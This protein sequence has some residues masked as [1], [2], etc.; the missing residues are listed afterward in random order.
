MNGKN[1]NFNDKKI[2]K[3]NFYKNKKINNIED[4][5]VDNILVSKKEPYGTLLDI[6]IMILLDHPLC[7]KLPQMTGYISKFNENLTMSFRVKDKQLLKNYNKIWEKVEKLMKIDFESK[8]VYGND[9]KYIKTKIKTYE[10]SIITNF[11]DKKTPKEKA[12]Y[13]CLSIIMIDSVIKAN[14]KYYPQPLLEE[15]KYIQKKMKTENY[16]DEELE[17]SESDSESNSE[18]ESDTDNEE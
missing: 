18:T 10:K 15:C 11:H 4:I 8:P 2:R 12:S 7:I 6:M 1:I 17:K 13:K 16:I 9:D 5:D 3:S 14:K